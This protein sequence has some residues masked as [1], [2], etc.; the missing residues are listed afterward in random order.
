[1]TVPQKFFVAA[2]DTIPYVVGVAG[3]HTAPPEK[4]K[5]PETAMDGTLK[6]GDRVRLVR[7]IPKEADIE[8]IV[9]GIMVDDEGVWVRFLDPED[10]FLFGWTKR[11]EFAAC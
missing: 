10:G 1:L 9:F 6:A 7:A 3:E 5:P 2:V 11:A 4:H 8:Y